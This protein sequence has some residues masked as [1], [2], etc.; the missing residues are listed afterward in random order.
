LPQA[1]AL[2]AVTI[3]AAEI[4]GVGSTRLPKYTRLY[5]KYLNRN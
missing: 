1:G 2:K 3:N 5:E 4:W